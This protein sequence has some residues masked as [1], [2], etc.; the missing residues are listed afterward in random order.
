MTMGKGKCLKKEERQNMKGWV[1]GACAEILDKHIP[2]YSDAVECGYKAEEEFLRMVLAE[3]YHIVSWQLKDHE[4]PPRPWPFFD[5]AATY[6]PEELTEEEAREKSEVKEKTNKRIKQ[7]L[8]Y[9]V[10]K[11]NK[12][13]LRITKPLKA[14]QAYQEWMVE[15]VDAIAAETKKQWEKAVLEGATGRPG[16][17]VRMGVA[18]N[19]FAELSEVQQ[20]EWKVKAKETAEAN[21]R[22]YQNAL[23]AP[24]SKDP[25]KHELC[26]SGLPAFVAPIL[27]GIHERTGLNIVMLVGGPIPKEG[28]EIGTM[29]EGDRKAAA[30]PDIHGDVSLMPDNGLY[31]LDED[32]PG[33]V[34]NLDDVSDSSE[35]D[36][37]GNQKKRAKGGGDM[38]GKRKKGKEKENEESDTSDQENDG[39]KSL[40]SMKGKPKLSAYEWTRLENIERIKNNPVLKTLNEEI[41]QIHE[42][43][44]PSRPKP[45]SRAKKPYDTPSRRSGRLGTGGSD[46]VTSSSATGQPDL[47]INYT[48]A[49]TNST[50]QSSEK[51]SPATNPVTMDDSAPTPIA[52]TFKASNSDYMEIRLNQELNPR[53]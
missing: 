53:S 26:I 15:N 35:D 27:K 37:N 9:R 17:G 38:M 50:A 21:K 46:V 42:E 5:P 14:C 33:L 3:Y 24:P 18:R 49:M 13:R 52:A 25:W 11:L 41:R 4:E 6:A 43:R 44:D 47:T 29:N 19:L 32:L 20:A 12:K 22:E 31:M 23:K 8:C 34:E 10:R 30:L 28:G 40:G 36:D 45:K 16:V 7:Y 39:D 51:T 48:V 1:E 2:G